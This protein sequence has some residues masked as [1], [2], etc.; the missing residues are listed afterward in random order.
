MIQSGLLQAQTYILSIQIQK[1]SVW[2]IFKFIVY[3]IYCT[4]LK[5]KIKNQIVFSVGRSRFYNK[6][7]VNVLF[8][9]LLNLLAILLTTNICSMFK[10]NFSST[11]QCFIGM[12]R[13]FP[14]CVRLIL[15]NHIAKCVTDTHSFQ[16]ISVLFMKPQ[17]CS[18]QFMKSDQ[19]CLK[20]QFSF[21]VLV[22]LFWIQLYLILIW[23]G[24]LF[25]LQ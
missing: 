4:D 3:F 13:I 20:F 2:L 25:I 23:L 17:Y 7:Y 19:P 1:T 24:L 5:D 10:L 11:V 16:I 21:S 14:G 9:Y 18:K 8:S 22:A 6:T 12:L 15:R